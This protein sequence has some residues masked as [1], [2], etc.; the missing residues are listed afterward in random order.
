MAL[1]LVLQLLALSWP[2]CHTGVTSNGTQEAQ[3]PRPP[4]YSNARTSSPKDRHRHRHRGGLASFSLDS[5]PGTPPPR[6]S[7]PTRPLPPFLP[8]SYPE[9]RRSRPLPPGF[10]LPYPKLRQPTY[11]GPPTS[12]PKPSLVAQPAAVVTPGTNVTL[13]CRAPQPAW[14]FVLS[15][16]G[17]VSPVQIHYPDR[18]ES[19]ML[20]RFLLKAVTEAQGGSYRCEYH[21]HQGLSH[22]SDALELMVTGEVRRRGG[23]PQVRD[24]GRGMLTARLPCRPAGPAG[25]GSMDYT[26]GNVVRLVLAGLVLISLA[27][28]REKTSRRGREA[29][30]RP[31]SRLSPAEP[32]FPPSQ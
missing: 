4:M 26:K 6:P 11:S 14:R 28:R 29:V 10:P 8:R 20:A 3:G 5:F 22:P 12:P 24:L 1:V 21:N 23:G 7:W 32:R 30:G 13:T 31:A 27:L 16:A 19:L 2:L 25:S 17:E 15:K 9:I 18:D